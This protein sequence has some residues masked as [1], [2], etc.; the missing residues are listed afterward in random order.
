MTE[1]FDPYAEW[2]SIPKENRPIDHYSILGLERYASDTQLIAEAANQRMGMLRKYQSGPRGR[3]VN[4]VISDVTRAKICLLD[5][6]RKNAY[7][8]E[9]R[10][11]EEN[12]SL[13]LLLQKP[14]KPKEP[15][16][17][18]AADGFGSVANGAGGSHD[19]TRSNPKDPAAAPPPLAAPTPPPLAASLGA[20]T[21]QSLSSQGKGATI[22]TTV[23]SRAQDS[24]PIQSG[25]PLKRQA[26]ELR[27]QVNLRRRR[28]KTL[29][30]ALLLTILLLGSIASLIL[31]F[32]L[33]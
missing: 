15:P 24:F 31:Y 10:L 26:S 12:E 29:L 32:V 21:A 16:I 7:D 2:L 23:D 28:T 11:I 20:G 27:R 3:F 8:Q 19:S 18:R 4:Q 14:G 1:E 6:E 30:L 5:A 25:Y 13:G 17:E 9:L 33:G 22:Q